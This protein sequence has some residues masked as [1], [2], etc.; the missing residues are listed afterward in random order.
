LLGIERD[1]SRQILGLALPIIG[2]M[3]S[4]NVLNLVDTLMVGQL[5]K[6][7]LA[8]VGFGGFANFMATAFITGMGA[9]VQAMVSR[10]KGEGRDS[11]T[12]V[13]LNGGLVIVSAIALP[14]SLI[15]IALAPTIFD[16]L[17]SD[18]K[19]VEEGI[20]YLRAR[21]IAVIAV[22]ANFAF[23]GYWNGV[24]LSKLY[25]RTLVVMHACNVV[26]NF[27]LIFGMLGVPAMGTTGAGLG[28]AIATFIGTGYYFF[29]GRRYARDSGFLSGFPSRATLKTIMR[30]SV[31][32]GVQTFLFAA[33]LTTLFAIIDRV[34]TAE[35][36]AASVV[37]NISLVAFLPGL[38]LGLAAASLV[39]QALGRGDVD[40]ATRW[41]WEVVRIGVVLMALIG[42]PMALIPELIL[43]PFFP[44]EPGPLALATGPLRLAGWTIG[45]EALTMI[46]LNTIVGAGATTTALVIAVVMQWG[47]FLPLAYIFGPLRGGDLMTIWIINVGHRGL[48]AAILALVW[49][50]RRWA[51]VKL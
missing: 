48:M 49:R 22:G 42:L 12:A 24:N 51:N 50:S 29:L 34:G 14:L 32:S 3:V 46:L 4:Q 45:V 13:P 8:A 23:R 2:G 7:A 33:G 47:V 20:P 16:A 36:A 18:P 15:L 25:L 10:R 19:V 40:D 43:A 26:L 30:V 37:I 6:E 38:G 39:G 31:P 35:A 41:G 27:V 17:S 44:D 1:R 21:L 9:G 28:T 5:G 11:E